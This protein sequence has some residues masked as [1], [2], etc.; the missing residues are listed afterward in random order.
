MQASLRP[1]LLVCSLLTAVLTS[2]PAL[3]HSSGDR[4]PTAY[5]WYPSHY[6][7]V[8]RAQDNAAF[9]E[10]SPPFTAFLQNPN[11]TGFSFN[12]TWRAVEPAPGSYNFSTVDRLIETAASR[13]K[14]SII[15][16]YDR[17]FWN[18]SC[19]Q[20]W[21][22]DA[23]LPDFIPG[24]N[25]EQG[26]CV[27]AFWQADVKAA[28]IRLVAALAARYDRDPRVAAIFL[29]ESATD[30]ADPSL[31]AQP[32]KNQ[33]FI[34]LVIQSAKQFQHTLV[35]AHWNYP[36]E[37]VHQFLQ[38]KDEWISLGIGLSEPDALPHRYE[39]PIAAY[40][41]QHAAVLPIMPNMDGT[42]QNC[43]TDTPQHLYNY[44]KNTAHY[45]V[46]AKWRACDE[47]TYPATINSFLQV[48][49][50]SLQTSC[51]TAILCQSE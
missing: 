17:A 26:G 1:Y 28:Y 40:S 3:A 45:L 41:R 50:R 11:V 51:P 21:H 48:A 25:L 44:H 4:P 7:K 43:E 9:L 46:W 22:Q 39:A 6:I 14:K 16:I 13:G 15:R 19:D 10:Q 8:G 23:P 18:V 47:E 35:S 32:A 5:K 31:V 49:P 29:E 24:A 37:I 36:E 34:D 33:A 27:A 38:R 12:I 2:V 20:T 42:L 30:L